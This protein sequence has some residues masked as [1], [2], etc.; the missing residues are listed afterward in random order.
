MTVSIR[1]DLLFQPKPSKQAPL[2]AWGKRRWQI[3]GW[4]K[5]AKHRRVRE[6]ALLHLPP[7][8]TGQD[9][10]ES[11]GSSLGLPERLPLCAARWQAL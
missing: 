3:E 5:T 1:N 10:Y 9:S 7:L 4:F 8:R 11:S 6:Y 2:Q